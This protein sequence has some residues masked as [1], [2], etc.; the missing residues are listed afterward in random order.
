MMKNW[1]ALCVAILGCTLQALAQGLQS[2]DPW[3]AKDLMQPKDLA[4]QMK[5]HRHPDVLVVFVGFPV[6]YRNAHVPGAILAGPC[7]KP[8]GLEALKRAVQHI[9]RT[10]VIEIYCGCCPF[11][12]CPN[13]RPAFRALRQMGFSNVKVVVMDTNFHTDWAE[14]GYPVQR[15]AAE[16]VR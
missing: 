13:V 11:V 3:N 2:P 12:K 1:G 7:S 6:L 15:P 8:D 14:K 5:D 4:A 9:P 16:P 10:R